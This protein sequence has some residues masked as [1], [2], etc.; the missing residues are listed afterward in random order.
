M[1]IERLSRMPS[2]RKFFAIEDGGDIPEG[3]RL[4][5]SAMQE[6]KIPAKSDVVTYGAGCEDGMYIILSGSC[7][8]LS[9]SGEK[10]NTSLGEGDF[11]GELALMNDQPRSA[12]VR[13]VTDVSCANISKQLFEE[14]GSSNRK[15]YGSFMTMLYNRTTHLVKEQERV[16]TELAVASRIQD[17]L[18]EHD[19]SEFNE[20]DHVKLYAC[21]RP[22][23]EMGG[24]FYDMFMIDEDHLCFLIAD[25]SGKGIP[26]AMF[27]SMAK[28]HIKNYA[29]LGLPL[30]EV[31]IRTND[32]L[33][34]KNEEE[35]FVTVFL[36]VL[37]LK[38]NELKF[39]NA[40]HGSPFVSRAGGSFTA[41]KIKTNIAFGIYEGVKYIEQSMLLEP[42]DSIYIYTD[43]VNEANNK[44]WEMFGNERLE[45]ALNQNK[46]LLAEPE[47]LVGRLYGEIDAFAGEA[48]QSDD[49]TMVYLTRR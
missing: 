37:D 33:C 16:R 5:L 38:T 48:E 20:L 1:D 44:D 9:A 7:E 47:K 11:V 13:A 39:I 30:D 45:A 24:D 6:V 35:M 43:G 2:I 17:G 12:T 22:A 23:K 19:F 25:V 36:C 40:A 14:I 29:S 15:I 42:G 3:V 4:F 31:A 28:I 41:P 49:I 8:V 26:A 34:Y 32:Q 27:M 10:I 18:L 46:E 21:T